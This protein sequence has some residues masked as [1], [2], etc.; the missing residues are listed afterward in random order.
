MCRTSSISRPADGARR[1]RTRST[2]ARRR[3]WPIS[4]RW[5]TRSPVASTR[6]T[7]D[8]CNK[9]FAAATPPEGRRAD[10]HA[11]GGRSRSRAI[12]WY[13]PEQALCAARYVLSGP[14]GQEPAAGSVHAVSELRAERL[15]AA[16]QIRRRRLSRRRQGD[17]RQRGQPLG[18]RQFHHRLA[19][20][21]TRCGRAMPPNSRRTAG[22]FRRSPPASPAAAWRAAPSARRSTPRTMP[23]S[24]ATAASRSR[25]STRTASR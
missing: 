16:A 8:A 5:P 6:V 24:P 2:A 3:R 4:R 15:G 25:C 10:R 9:L 21:R 19:G 12:P 1:S 7:A 11:D 14:A 18:R 20:R 17:V 13:Q 22:R 23:G